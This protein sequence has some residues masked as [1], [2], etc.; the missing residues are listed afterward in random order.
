[1][2]LEQQFCK[3]I[4]QMKYM[5]NGERSPEEVFRGISKEIASAEKPRH[6]KH[7]E[8]VFYEAIASRKFIPGGRIL[9]NARPGSKLRNYGNCYVIPISDSLP[10]IY[11]ALKE[12]AIISG[13]GGGVGFNI[14]PLRP[15]NAPIKKGGESSGPMSFGEVFD[16]SAKVIRNG[17]GRRSAHIL[18]MDV[19]HPDIEE[20]ITYKQ[21]DTNKKLTSFNISVGI[22]QEFIDA[23]KADADW[24]LVHDGLV[25]KTVKARELLQKIA[26]HAF[27]HNEPGI[28]IYPSIEKRNFGWYTDEIGS[29][30]A[31][32]PCGEQP[33]PPYGVCN[34]S[35]VNL[36]QL[37]VDAF[38]DHAYFD[39]Q[40][41]RRITSIAVRFSDNVIDVMDYPL[42]KIKELQRKSR[43]I[44]VG[45]T[46]LG[47]ALA[48]L[49]MQYGDDESI[50]FVSLLGFHLRDTS[51]TT[52]IALA[53]EK[54][55]YPLFK[56][57]EYMKTPF[58]SGFSAEH[59]KLIKRYG[60]R[61]ITLNTIAPVGTGSIALGMNCSS[62]IEPIF[63]LEYDR[64]VRVGDEG[65]TVTQ[66]NYNYAYLV[67]KEMGLTPQIDTAEEID[68]YRAMAV[69]AAMQAYIDSS[70]SKTYNLPSTYQ[71]EDYEKLVFAAIDSGLV[72]FTSYNPKGS[73]APILSTKSS[74][75]VETE[76]QLDDRPKQ[77]E[78]RSAPKR[79]KDLPCDIHVVS[80]KG[81]KYLLL[82][83]MYEDYPYEVFATEANA[84]AV[85]EATLKKG[86][87]G[88]I[89]KVRRG[90]YSL[91][92][93]GEVLLE[94]IG[95]A[96]NSDYEPLN[97]MLSAALRHGTPIE[98]AVDA[99]G[100]GSIFGTWG[101]MVS[102]VLKKY[103]KDGK[104]AAGEVC[105]ECGGKVVYAEGCKSCGNGCGWSKCS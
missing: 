97:R 17:G 66:T 6:R 60:M 71:Y 72:G 25:Y 94:N 40:E 102:V 4:F 75:K 61:N 54:G 82:V 87:R 76:Q 41:F 58:A 32:N 80:V 98:Y 96:F 23:V 57:D 92:L 51:V 53:K 20:F 68:P 28:L 2:H 22:S 86:S 43:R 55:K 15:K 91:L 104:T 8:D 9:A 39:W 5:I 69:Q 52:S 13:A 88:V 29:I 50:P 46:G 89:R 35:A 93:N 26:Q 37:V 95:D 18:L 3:D 100:K 64:K 34:L 90:R 78:H 83:G 70:I 85:A 11:D 56:Y 45:I 12:D 44:G 10:A 16:S 7:W 105:P 14:S 99:L 63:S 49:G 21:G 33:L 84:D 31:C 42:P 67:A 24:H 48:M 1:M 73:L 38:T 30:N 19:S 79:P 36:S 47:D 101:K 81:V 27:I 59:K 103:I 74:E 77:F 62:G 65:E